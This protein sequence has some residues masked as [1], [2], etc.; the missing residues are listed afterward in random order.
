MF[1]VVQF[2]HDINVPIRN[3]RRFV[4]LTVINYATHTICMSNNI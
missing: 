1:F 3:T 2:E 4:R